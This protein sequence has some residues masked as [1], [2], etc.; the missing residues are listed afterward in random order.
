M[1]VRRRMPAT[2]PGQL[3]LE[4]GLQ[5]CT[6]DCRAPATF[7][8]DHN[9]PCGVVEES[10]KAGDHSTH[11]SRPTLLGTGR[12]GLV[13]RRLLTSKADETVKIRA[14]QRGDEEGKRG[15]H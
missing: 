9:I 8:S 14:G 7:H 1:M 13:A 2:G 6:R 5:A 15:N 10:G 11:F 3:L 4:E 12:R